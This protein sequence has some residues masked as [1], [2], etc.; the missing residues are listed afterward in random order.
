MIGETLGSYRVLSKLGEGGMGTVYLAEH[1]LIGRRAAVKVLLPQFSNDQEML[2]R[3]FNEARATATLRHPAL[4]DVFDFGTHVQTGCAFL[5]MDYLEGETLMSRLR[6]RQGIPLANAVD[7]ALQIAGGAAAAHDAGIVHRDLKPENIFLLPDPSRPGFD[8]VKILDFGIAKLT[9]AAFTSA[10][11]RTRSGL[12]LGTPLYMSPEQCRGVTHIDLRADVYSLGCILFAM[13]LGRPPFDLEFSGDLIAAHL[14]T[15][16]PRP[17]LLDPAVPPEMEAVI[18]KALAKDPRDRYQT[19]AALAEELKLVPAGMPRTMILPPRNTPYVRASAPPAM[20][21]QYPAGTTLSHAASATN[22][23]T[24]VRTRWKLPALVGGLIVGIAGAVLVPKLVRRPQLPAPTVAADP[25]PAETPPAPPPATP[26]A[27]AVVAKPPEPEPAPPP[28]PV[29]K[30]PAPRPA[31]ELPSHV[32]VEVSNA[33][34]GL[35]VTL[36]GQPARL[37]LRLRRDGAAHV[38]RFEAPNFKPETKTIRADRDVKLRLKYSP[39]L[40]M[41]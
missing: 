10:A 21:A 14:N 2:A 17:T 25:A 15:P 31:R 23:I 20:P 41:E 4:V 19:M 40:F 5:I 3:F 13:V 6:S 34:P 9:N 26:T 22:S 37:P 16:P 12:I 1:P 7:L 27:A 18:L 32:T 36:D 8:R 38:V 11:S 30:E 24:E 39:S 29:A 28:A 33:R 35:S